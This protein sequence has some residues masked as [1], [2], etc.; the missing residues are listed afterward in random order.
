MGVVTPGGAKAE[1]TRHRDEELEDQAI[2]ELSVFDGQIPAIRLEIQNNSFKHPDLLVDLAAPQ[3]FSRVDI[4]PADY[5][6]PPEPTTTTAPPPTTAPAQQA[7]EAAV[8]PEPEEVGP[9]PGA[10]GFSGPKLASKT[11][12]AV[13]PSIKFGGG[14]PPKRNAPR[15]PVQRALEQISD[16]IRAALTSPGKFLELLLVWTVMAVPVYLAARRRLVVDSIL[17]P[18]QEIA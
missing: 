2:N 7:T 1:V 14:A 10:V 3:A 15:S 16:G 8:E 6:P 13:T 12:P 11:T 9:P 17:G 4:L 5:T 18:T